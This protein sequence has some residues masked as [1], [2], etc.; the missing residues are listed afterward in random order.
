MTK[1]H[2]SSLMAALAITLFVG[3]A[4]DAAFVSFV[5]T[6]KFDVSGTSVL[7]NLDGLDISFDSGSAGP[8]EL[9]NI[10]SFSNVS[11][12]Q[13]NTSFTSATTDQVVSSGFTLSIL[14][15]TPSQDPSLTFSGSIS[16][17]VSV[18]G[19]T[20]MVQFNGPLVLTSADGRVRYRILNAEEGT[21]GLISVGSPNAN[22]SLSSVNGRI[23]LVPEPS[24]FALL[25]LGVP[26]VLLYRRRRA[27]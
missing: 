20:L 11:F 7:Q 4:A 19:S 5:T 8:I 23:T 15:T 21:P 22:N 12:G 9:A 18:N 6:G 16:G 3:P 10:G 26:A 27:A 14:Q 25:G 24:A 13:F 17:T 1:I 2:T